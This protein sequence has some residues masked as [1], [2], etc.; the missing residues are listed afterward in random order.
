VAR[1]T[2]SGTRFD[3]VILAACLG[4]S[5]IATFLPAGTREN[6]A[7]SIRDTF[8]GPLIALQ[9]Q[10]ERARGAFVLRD[11]TAERL[12]SLVL[13]NAELRDM[14]QE[15]TRLRELIGLGARL[16][17]PFVAAEALHRPEH[18]VAHAVVVTAGSRAGVVER[19]AVVAP[20]GLIGT[21]VSVEEETSTALLWT[22]PDFG[23]S[24]V[25]ADGKVFGI[26]KPHFGD[27]ADRFLLELRNVAFRDS[28]KAGTEIR[29]SGLGTV[30]P[31]GIP[32]GIV[33]SEITTPGAYARTY[34][35]KP[36]VLPSD[37]SAVMVLLPTN[38]NIE[39]AWKSA[40]ADS[41]RRAIDRAADSLSRLRPDT[42]VRDTGVV[43]GVRRG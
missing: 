8:V 30:F 32:I 34:L 35:I 26:I 5:L 7:G 40:G 23:V 2:R 37:V 18:G 16:P 21:V 1:A 36:A 29:S 13:R 4:A 20:E 38:A 19:S 10:A 6:V 12:D 27:D 33:V 39:S 43:G 42:V 3:T 15:N 41:L 24:A 28:L 31:R 17:T 14:E 11:I 25:S 9:V 22:H